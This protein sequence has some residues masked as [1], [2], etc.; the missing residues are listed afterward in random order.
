MVAGP[1]HVSLARSRVIGGRPS[2][3]CKM[4]QIGGNAA[5]AF[6]GRDRIYSALHQ[7]RSFR[8]GPRV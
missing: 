4:E 5:Q 8:L 6:A 2:N 1:W 7:G 3:F